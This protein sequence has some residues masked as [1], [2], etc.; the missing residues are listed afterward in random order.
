MLSAV[1]PTFAET[2][3][4]QML[5]HPKMD[6]GI[7]RPLLLPHGDS[8]RQL[9][10]ES[11]MDLRVGGFHHPASLVTRHLSGAARSQP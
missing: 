5:L 11:P 2:A 3:H 8:K 4:F 6:I 1:P 10:G 7:T 9:P